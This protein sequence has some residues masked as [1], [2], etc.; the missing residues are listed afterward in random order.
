M[1]VECDGYN[2]SEKNLEEFLKQDLLKIRLLNIS[3]RMNQPN[4][5]IETN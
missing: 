2:Y 4:L 5:L 1:P 3:G